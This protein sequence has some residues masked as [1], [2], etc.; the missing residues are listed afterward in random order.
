MNTYE[1]VTIQSF[2]HEDVTIEDMARA[3][4]SLDG[5]LDRFN[6]DKN[7]PE[8][9]DGTYSGYCSEVQQMIRRANRYVA[10]RKKVKSE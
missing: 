4:A 7:S 2:L 9:L 8:T 5:K 1:H 3:W 10:M 6:H